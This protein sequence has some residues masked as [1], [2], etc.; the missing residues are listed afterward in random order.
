LGRLAR[1]KDIILRLVYIGDVFKV[2][3]LAT[4]TRDSHY[5]TCLGHLGWCDTDVIV[6]VG[7]GK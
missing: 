4:L 7:Q 6:A 2:E 3:M 5:C 1:D